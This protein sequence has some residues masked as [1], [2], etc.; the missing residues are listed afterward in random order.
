MMGFIRRL[1][2]GSPVLRTVGETPGIK[3]GASRTL[4][5]VHAL[6]D[7]QIGLEV[8]AKTLLSYQM[9]PVTL[10]PASASALAQA[11]DLAAAEGRARA[12]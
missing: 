7:G 1:L 6:G 10:D 9:L 12:A 2:F 8:V 11:L 5:K 4:V 3:K